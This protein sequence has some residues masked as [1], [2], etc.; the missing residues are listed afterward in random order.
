MLRKTIDIPIELYQDIQALE[1]EDQV[2]LQAA[3]LAT[4]NAY[5]PYS[6]F[7]VGAALRLTNGQLMF[8]NTEKGDC[9]KNLVTTID[10]NI[11]LP[12][13]LFLKCKG[14]SGDIYRF[15]AD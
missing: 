11:G 13:R 15:G 7:R 10:L 12:K 5:A 9:D 8:T 14:E 3:R 1:K 2:L 4:E 6:K